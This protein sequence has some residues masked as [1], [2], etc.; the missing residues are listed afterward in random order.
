MLIMKALSI[1]Q[2]WAWFI[3]RRFKPVENR[4]WATNYRG[5]LL[6]HASKKYDTGMDVAWAE[7]L[8]G[9]KLPPRAFF[10][11]LQGGICGIADQTD[12]VTR[13]PSPWLSGPHGF[14]L[15]NAAPVPFTPYRGM[16]GLFNVPETAV[17]ETISTDYA[18][19]LHLFTK[20]KGDTF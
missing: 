9:A 8:I 18:R 13:H 12:C 6:I 11:R 5:P 3:V 14:V 16:Q 19:R 17:P 15:D 1:W 2:P 20:P 7:D 4:L 10:D